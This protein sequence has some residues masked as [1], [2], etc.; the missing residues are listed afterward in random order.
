M[1]RMGHRVVATIQYMYI[2]LTAVQAV[3]NAAFL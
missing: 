1:I 3:T 2:Y